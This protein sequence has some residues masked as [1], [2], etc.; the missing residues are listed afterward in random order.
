MRNAPG[1]DLDSR[2]DELPDLAGRTVLDLGCGPGEQAA[3]LAAR[4]AHVIGIDSNEDAVC[5]ARARGLPDAQFRSADLRAIP[6]CGVAID[7]LWSSFSAAYFP[8]LPPVLGG[9]A[10]ELRPGGWAALTEIDDFLAHEPLGARARDLLE[11]YARDAYAARRY[12]FHM[13]R[14][15]RGHLESAG[16]TVKLERILEDPELAF[17]GPAGPPVLEAWR[18][19]FE[20]M[21]LLQSFCG[22]DWEPLRDEFLAC[23]ARPDHRSRAKIYFCLAVR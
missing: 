10:K 17:D 16:F 4:G 23:L 1:A 11:A 18:R 12:D 21:P 20:R 3:V 9:W 2:F 13:G 5:Q 22:T 7:G 6:D 15:L 14:K 8:D 19:R